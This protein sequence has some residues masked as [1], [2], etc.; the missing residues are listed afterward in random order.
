MECVRLVWL[1]GALRN[2]R[3]VCRIA[4]RIVAPGVDAT[5]MPFP[6]FRAL[7]DNM[8]KLDLLHCLSR[9][10]F[11]R[12]GDEMYHTTR[13]ISP[14]SS[15]QGKYDYYCTVE[16]IMRMKR[17]IIITLEML[18]FKGF[19]RV[20]RSLTTQ[21]LGRGKSSV[22]VKVN[23]TA[24]AIILESGKD[25]NREYRSE[26]YGFLSDQAGGG[27]SA[28]SQKLHLATKMKS[29][30]PCA[31]Y[32]TERLWHTSLGRKTYHRHPAPRNR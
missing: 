32:A 1:I 14:D 13:N 4:A 5:H 8:I 30:L 23:K 10:V 16:E 29:T 6:S 27:G 2:F 3:E 15:P 24:G 20:R 18:P 26:V 17:P 9:R 19:E 7:R 22:A 31:H 25:K 28:E 11:Y 12:R 21:T